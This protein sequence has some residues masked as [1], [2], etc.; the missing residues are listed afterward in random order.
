M[1]QVPQVAK[2]AI[3]TLRAG[4][5]MPVGSWCCPVPRRC[6]CFHSVTADRFFEYRFICNA[7]KS[8]MLYACQSSNRS[9]VELLSETL[10]SLD[11]GIL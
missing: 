7:D 2:R 11:E 1:W 6:Y 8:C 3:V 9:K 4:I 10:D 5:V